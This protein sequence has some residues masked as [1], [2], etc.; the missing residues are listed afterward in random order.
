MG[1]DAITVALLGRSRPLGTVLAGLLFGALQAGGYTMQSRT[2]TPIDVVLVLQ[3]LIVLLIAAP[4]L[5]RAVFFLPGRRRADQART[6]GG[7]TR[8]GGGMTTA[9][10]RTAAQ[11]A[12]RARVPRRAQTDQL[13]G[14]DRLRRDRADQ[15]GGVRASR[16]VRR[17]H[18]VH[19]RAATATGSRSRRS[20]CRPS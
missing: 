6:E 5:V 8:G 19:L 1:F 13:Q 14:A 10:D 15:P 20:A 7:A 11:R 12:G 3:S 4:P 17:G 2:G 9:A 18:H 16:A